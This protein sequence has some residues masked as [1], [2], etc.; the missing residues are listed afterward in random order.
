MLNIYRVYFA[1]SKNKTGLIKGGEYSTVE[2]FMRM[3]IDIIQRQRHPP[4]E[5]PKLNSYK[6]VFI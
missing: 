3:T 2:E 6:F 1:K 5:W 4:L